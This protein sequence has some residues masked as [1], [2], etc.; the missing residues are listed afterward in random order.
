MRNE[1]VGG[2]INQGEPYAHSNTSPASM[3]DSFSFRSSFSSTESTDSW[4]MGTPS[5][6]SRRDDPYDAFEIDGLSS[7]RT[8]MS[9]SPID[10]VS[11]VP[12][13]VLAMPSTNVLY[14]AQCTKPS[15]NM[16]MVPYDLSYGSGIYN[17]FQDDFHGG[18]HSLGFENSSPMTVGN[19]S[20]SFQNFVDPSQ[21]FYEPFQPATPL[22][23][24]PRWSGNIPSSSPA[25]DYN[26]QS[27]ELPYFMSPVQSHSD[28]H[29]SGPSATPTRVKRSSSRSPAL[30]TSAALHRIQDK[31]IKRRK[32]ESPPTGMSWVK[33]GNYFCDYPGC[34]KSKNHGF[35]RQEHLK[36]HKLTHSAP[37]DLA[38]PFPPCTKRWQMDRKDNWKVHVKL[39]AT[40]D[41]KNKRTPFVPEAVEFLAKLEK[42]SQE[43]KEN[44]NVEALA[45]AAEI[46]RGSM[47]RNATR[48]ANATF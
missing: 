14:S 21:T 19:L 18:S 33:A 43:D 20:L 1:F 25:T 36:R 29:S 7:S 15:M 27:R 17:D 37:K 35:M 48:L 40:P 24:P 41:K 8:S 23:T 22:S 38:C 16:G 42:Q 31:T 32:T 3:T 26:C 34:A 46:V 9:R 12:Y 39:H 6:S 2:Y 5:P 11:A 28:I 10:F 47:R 30:A 44:Q 4:E 45:P 13:N